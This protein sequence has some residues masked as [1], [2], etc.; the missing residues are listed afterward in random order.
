MTAKK[1]VRAWQYTTFGDGFLHD[2]QK[3]GARGHGP[4]TSAV[5]GG[6][7]VLHTAFG[8]EYVQLGDWVVETDNDFH[9]V[10]PEFFA[11][12]FEVSA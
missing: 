12:H 4:I 10:S 3:H 8:D 5:R 6:K 2:I 1:R 7:I 9:C 11:E